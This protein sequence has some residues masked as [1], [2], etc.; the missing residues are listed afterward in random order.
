MISPE[1]KKKEKKKKT[2]TTN[3]QTNIK[4][5][6]KVSEKKATITSLLQLPIFSASCIKYAIPPPP[7]T[8]SVN[9]LMSIPSFLLLM[10]SASTWGYAL[11][12]YNPTC[13]T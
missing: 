5:P 2:R 9:E 3:K 12:F 11:N 8:K 10:A 6:E 13:D 7:R 4:K 1:K